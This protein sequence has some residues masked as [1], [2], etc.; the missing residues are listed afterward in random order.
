MAISRISAFLLRM[1]AA[2]LIV[3]S[4]HTIAQAARN[5]DQPCS[6]ISASSHSQFDKNHAQLCC[7]VLHCC[8]LL[9]IAAQADTRRCIQA[10][11]ITPVLDLGPLFLVRPLYP[12]PKLLIIS[13]AI[14]T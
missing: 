10:V 2:A 14:L 5:S 3:A 7:G 11:D 8:I 9:P 6:P 1:F 12:P 13:P 4:L